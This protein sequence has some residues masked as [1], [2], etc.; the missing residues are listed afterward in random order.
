ML[1]KIFNLLF[2]RQFRIK[3]I[4]NK[5]LTSLESEF[6]GEFLELLLK[7]MKLTLFLN[8][9]FRKNIKGFSGRYLFKSK[10]RSITVAVVFKNKKMKV[11]EKIIDNTNVTVTFKDAQALMNYILSPKP[12]ILGAIL[13]QEVVFEGNLNYLYKFAYMSRRLQLMATGNI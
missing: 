3:R 13:R 11:L 1:E 9:N 7:L 6:A 5:F 8:T 10:D 12:D 4:K 2:F